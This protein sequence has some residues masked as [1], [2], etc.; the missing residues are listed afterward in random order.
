MPQFRHWYF[1]RLWNNLDARLINKKSS[2][3]VPLIKINGRVKAG[4][5]SPINNKQP[6]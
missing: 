3:A 6:G 2:A 4:A 5:D 1:L